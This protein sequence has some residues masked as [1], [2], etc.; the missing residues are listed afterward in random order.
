MVTFAATFVDTSRE[1]KKVF[2]WALLVDFISAVF[3]IGYVFALFGFFVLAILDF[4]QGAVVDWK[5]GTRTGDY[6]FRQRLGAFFTLMLYVTGGFVLQTF[7]EYFPEVS[8]GYDALRG[9]APGGINIGGTLS[10]LL[11]AKGVVIFGVA[12]YYFKR[13]RAKSGLASKR[14]IFSKSSKNKDA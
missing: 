7:L 2:P 3:G 13:L 5:D 10:L 1:L 12:L 14:S 8:K 9:W 4:A 6:T 11:N